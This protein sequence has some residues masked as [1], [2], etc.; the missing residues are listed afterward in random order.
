MKSVVIKLDTATWSCCAEPSAYHFGGTLQQYSKFSSSNAIMPTRTCFPTSTI[1]LFMSVMMLHDFQV[2]NSYMDS[3]SNLSLNL[4]L[5]EIHD[6]LEDLS[7]NE[8]PEHVI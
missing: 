2:L 6:I 5:E 7:P 1:T 4:F 8:I 3:V